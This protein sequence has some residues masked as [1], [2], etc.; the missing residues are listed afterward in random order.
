[1]SMNLKELRVK[2]NFSQNEIAKKVGLTQF[3]YSNYE[4]GTTEPKIKTLIDLANIYNVSIDYLI[5]REFNNEFGYLDEAEKNIINNY[6]QMNATNKVR[7]VA[8]SYGV[9]IGQS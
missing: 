8:E 5:G 4:T 6:R 1:M 3:T 7:F 9:L 2:N